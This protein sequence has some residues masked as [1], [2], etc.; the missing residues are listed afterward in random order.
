MSATATDGALPG[1]DQLRALCAEYGVDSADAQL[2]HARSN[3]V[4]LLP[5]DD[6]VI[7]M[8]PATDLR[9]Q[10]ARTTVMVTRWLAEQDPTIALAPAGGDQPVEA[11]GAIATFWPYRP[12]LENPPMHE[13]ADLIRRLH[14]TP[15]PPFPVPPHEPLVRLRE[16]LADD[17]ARD[18]PV[19]SEQDRRWLQNRAEHLVQTYDHTDWPLGKGLVHCDVH[20]E[21]VVFSDGWKLIDFDQVCLGPREFDLVSALPDHFHQSEAERR[22]L[23]TAYGYDLLGWKGWVVVR[24]IIEMHSLSSYLRLASTVPA[25]AT[26]LGHRVASLRNGDRTARWTAVS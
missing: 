23:L 19:L 2:L 17:R 20:A 25:A 10:R 24:D 26:E 1:P 18:E 13:I 8:A 11:A 16:A 9:R 21:N 7:R 22:A 3:A 5:H 12:A 15:A 14:N 4:Y 6:L